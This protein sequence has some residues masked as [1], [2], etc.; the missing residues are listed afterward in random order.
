MDL[1]RTILLV[2]GI[3]VLGARQVHGEPTAIEPLPKEWAPMAMITGFHSLVHQ[4][5]GLVLRVLEADGSSSVAENPVSLFIVATN[6]GTSD[7]REHVWRLPRGVARVK[8][9]SASKCGLDILVDMDVANEAQG[10]VKQKPATISA[11]FIDAKEELQ[12]CLQVSEVDVSA[13]SNK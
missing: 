1:R 11:C 7:L 3:V 9:V 6:Q 2:V 12:S 4:K 8:K 10:S 13:A 5:S